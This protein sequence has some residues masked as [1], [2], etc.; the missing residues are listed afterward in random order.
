[1]KA[2]LGLVIKDNLSDLSFAFLASTVDQAYAKNR[3][4]NSIML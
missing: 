1:M 4:A 2:E 3:Y